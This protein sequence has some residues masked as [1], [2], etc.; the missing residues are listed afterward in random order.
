M[1]LVPKGFK[2]KKQQKGKS[3]KKVSSITSFKSIKFNTVELISCEAGKVSA[4]QLNSISLNL[5]KL[6]KKVGVVTF[7][8][9]PYTPVTKKPIEV[10]MGKGKGSVDHWVFKCKI[11][12]PLLTIVTSSKK[13]S[14]LALKLIQ[15]KLPIKTKIKNSYAK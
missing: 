1:K 5:K 9:F 14:N 13:K 12:V 3:F 11:G 8:F 10:R 6:I 2:Y 4:K 15:I 7:K